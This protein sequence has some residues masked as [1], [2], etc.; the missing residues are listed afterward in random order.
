MASIQTAVRVAQ[1]D[2]ENVQT[3]IDEI[4]AWKLVTE[5]KEKKQG[6]LVWMSL[7]KNDP[8]N[9]K[10]S[11]SN[12]I[13]MDD[14]NKDNGLDKLIA[15][16]KE[17]FLEEGEIE[18]FSK[19]KEF[20]GVKRKAGENVKTYVNRFRTAYKT[21]AKKEILIPSSTRSFIVV[22]KAGISEELKRR[23]MTS[24]KQSTTYLVRVLHV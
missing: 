20:D 5:V 18:A 17:A 23:V 3:Y 6:P 7:P 13:G 21:I 10:Q 22:Q 9:I 12:S 4:S 8:N 14:L 19:W 16:L 24:F 11:V 2:Q 1:F 15:V